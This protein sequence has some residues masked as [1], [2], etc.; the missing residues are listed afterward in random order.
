MANEQ[1]KNS[2]KID[3]NATYLPLNFDIPKGKAPGMQVQLIS[4]FADQKSYIV[5]FKKGDEAFAGLHEFAEKYNIQNARF[6]AIGASSTIVLGWVCPKKKL[7]KKIS[8]EGQVELGALIGNIALFNGKP[9]V[10]AHAVVSAAD[11]TARAGHLFELHVWPTL[12]VM[13]TSYSVAL[14][15]EVDP[16]VGI[17]LLVPRCCG[18]E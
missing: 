5:V 8:P 16:E 4:E 7:Y 17:P 14:N 18:G 9:V 13:V 11:G 10:H 15:K 6:T 1:Q 2:L 3:D 12:E